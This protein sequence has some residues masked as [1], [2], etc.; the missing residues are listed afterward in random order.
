[1]KMNKNI[2]RSIDNHLLKKLSFI[3]IIMGMIL[4][5]CNDDKSQT[6]AGQTSEN[7]ETTVSEEATD[8]INALGFDIHML[9]DY[10]LKYPYI[11]ND[12]SYPFDALEPYFDKMTMEIHHGKHYAGYIATLNSS[13]ENQEYQD[14][15]LFKIFSKIS[16]YP[17]VIKNS[18]G[19][20]YNHYLFWSILT[21]SSGSQFIG[22]AA[23]EIIKKYESF[24]NFQNLFNEAAKSQFGSGWAW[25]CVD[26][27]G[28][29]FIT[30]TANQ[31]NPLM[32]VVEQ[33]G[34]PILNLDV[35]EHAYYLKYQNKRADYINQFWNII[36]WNEVNRRYIEAK[37]ILIK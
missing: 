23:D 31:D 27:N 29:L 20:Y 25:L 18:G 28:E 26:K 3:F 32:D 21:P 16:K 9:P 15:N 4:I 17:A 37:N 10:N 7:D 11:L 2:S 19:G 12:L 13:L 34:I 6:N 24:A 8:Q 14:I 5:S 35:W 1:M 30:N 33:Q 22:A 36:N